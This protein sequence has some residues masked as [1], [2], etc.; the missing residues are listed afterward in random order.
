MGSGVVT[1]AVEARTITEGSLPRAWRD[2]VRSIVKPWFWLLTVLLVSLGAA[3][4]PGGWQ[5]VAVAFGLGVAPFVVSLLWHIIVTPSRQRDEA[6]RREKRLE[7]RLANLP[8]RKELIK[9][10]LAQLIEA[11]DQVAGQ[12]SL[13]R[14]M[15]I[16]QMNKRAD[17][18][19]DRTVWNAV[20]LWLKQAEDYVGAELGEGEA[21]LFTTQSGHTVPTSLKLP[22]RFDAELQ[23]VRDRQQ[24]LRDLFQKS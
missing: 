8:G 21:I 13:A 10:G 23:L 5:R 2:T 19:F 16:A 7:E 18:D 24:R 9:K 17:I 12:L 1:D 4:T 11:G 22:D 20:G 14:Q 3:F 15:V 6:R